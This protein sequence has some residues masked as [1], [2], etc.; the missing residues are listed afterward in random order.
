MEFIFA[1]RIVIGG[2]QH[3]NNKIYEGLLRSVHILERIWKIHTNHHLW[4]K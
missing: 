1:I 2:Y 4:G 3:F